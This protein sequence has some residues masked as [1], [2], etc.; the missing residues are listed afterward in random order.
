MTTRRDIFHAFAPEYLER[1]PPLPASHRQV[2]RAIQQCHSGHYGHSLSQCHSCSNQHRVHH[3]C[4]NRHCPQGQQQKTQ[5]WLSH[6]L[7]RQLPGPHF[8]L[9]FTVP[10]TLRPF[11]R[12]HQRLAYPAMFPASSEAL[13]RRDGFD[14]KLSIRHGS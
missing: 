6:H 7:E 13:K 12:S 1:S 5:Q 14:R 3:A 8:L 11:I 10:E 9:T 2:I 4:G